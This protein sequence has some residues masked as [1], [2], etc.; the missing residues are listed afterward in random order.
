[1]VVLRQLWRGFLFLTVI[2]GLG[3]WCAVKRSPAP[4][5]HWFR[6]LPDPGPS[7]PLDF[8]AYVSLVDVLRDRTYPSKFKSNLLDIYSPKGC[9]EKTPTILWAHGGAFVAGDKSG[10]AYWCSM[11]ASKGYTVVSINYETA[12]EARYPAPVVQLA[13]VYAYLK[14]AVHEYPTLDLTRLIIGGDSAGAQI[15]SQFLAVQTNPELARLTGIGQTVPRE[16]IKA[17]LLYCGP[18]NVRRLAQVKGRVQKFYL[19]QLGW[20]YLG[21][22]N[23]SESAKAEHASTV[24]YVTSDFPPVF[25]TDGNTG[26][27]E[28]HGMELEEKLRSVGVP[29]TSLF[30]PLSHG[31]VQHEYQFQLNTNEA[32]KCFDMTLSFLE[33]R[34]HGSA[35]T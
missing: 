21:E 31:V 34:L 18:Y 5:I 12:P 16:T 28:K 30:F 9:R 3:I 27:F 1:M 10:T 23:W 24:H 13:E 8:E 20:A 26:S 14:T 2:A 17:A 19:N 22:R 4:F 29:V 6:R 7:A 25:I 15:A 11:M 35:P 33:E 32:I